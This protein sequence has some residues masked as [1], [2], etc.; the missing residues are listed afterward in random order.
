MNDVVFC[1]KEKDMVLYLF[2]M[3]KRKSVFFLCA[4]H[5]KP[6]TSRSVACPWFKNENYG[7]YVCAMYF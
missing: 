1:M 3:N 6:L 7:K 2:L 5:Y 4:Q